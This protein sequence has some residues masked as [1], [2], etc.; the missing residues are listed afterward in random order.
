MPAK[1][2]KIKLCKVCGEYTNHSKRYDEKDWRCVSQEH[3]KY[4]KQ[5]N[6]KEN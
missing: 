4:L 5:L 6:K 3:K 1:E 2:T